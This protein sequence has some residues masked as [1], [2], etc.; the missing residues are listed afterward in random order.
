MIRRAIPR[1]TIEE[2]SYNVIL[3]HYRNIIKMMCLMSSNTFGSA[4]GSDTTTNPSLTPPANIYETPPASNETSSRA[5]PTSDSDASASPTMILPP[6]LC[7]PDVELNLKS[8]N[9]STCVDSTLAS[10]SPTKGWRRILVNLA[11]DDAKPEWS[12]QF[13]SPD[14]LQ[15]E[16]HAELLEHLQKHRIDPLQLR[17][18]KFLPS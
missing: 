6:R 13:V 15:F 11:A 2:E 17:Y 5:S 3:L 7:D 12:I 18:V 1:S 9:N 16:N 14:G 8:T 4:P 10:D